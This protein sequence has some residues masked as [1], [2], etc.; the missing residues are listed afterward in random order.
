VANGLYDDLWSSDHA[1]LTFSL[2]Y[3]ICGL[4]LTGNIPAEWF[5]IQRSWTITLYGKN[6]VQAKTITNDDAVTF[7]IPIAAERDELLTIE[8]LSDKA[9]CPSKEF[10]SADERSLSFYILEIDVEK[11]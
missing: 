4:S 7:T 5:A 1:M 3:A 10:D 2:P 6:F 11:L 9:C 8:L